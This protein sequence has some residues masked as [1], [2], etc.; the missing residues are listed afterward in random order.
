MSKYI[1]CRN[2][3]AVA[4]LG[5]TMLSSL[6][7]C[8]T[9][10]YWP[11]HP[12]SGPKTP[13]CFP[14]N[15]W[16]GYYPTCWRKWSECAP[17]C[18]NCPEV[19]E[20][21]AKDN[22]ESPAFAPE[23]HPVAPIPQPEPANDSAAAKPAAPEVKSVLPE[24][25]PMAPAADQAPKPL[26]PK[27]SESKTVPTPPKPA[28]PISTPAAPS[29]AAVPAT[30]KPADAPAS[31]K[32]SQSLQQPGNAAASEWTVAADDEPTGLSSEAE[33]PDQPAA[34]IPVANQARGHETAL[35]EWRAAA[36]DVDAP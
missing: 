32:T 19:P 6:A 8:K 27:T 25:K 14:A 33:A 1:A 13:A 7:G 28:E 22:A 5:L 17:R 12:E 9:P 2:H 3:V 35:N 29:P 34:V 30:P 31:Q 16:G 23:K 18:R 15:A 4:L 21:K 11:H 24:P 36:D 10:P 26:T 20:A